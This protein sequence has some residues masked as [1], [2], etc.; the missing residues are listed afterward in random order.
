MFLILFFQYKYFNYTHYRIMYLLTCLLMLAAPATAQN[1]SNSRICQGFEQELRNINNT[2]N[3]STRQAL[4]YQQ[5]MQMQEQAQADAK[6]YSC[7]AGLFSGGS[8]SAEC[9]YIIM[10]Q[11]RL[12][13]AL[14]QISKQATSP[15]QRR[16][17]Q[18]IYRDMRDYNCRSPL[19]REEGV[20]RNR[21]DKRSATDNPMKQNNKNPKTEWLSPSLPPAT[22]ENEV[23]TEKPTAS[24]A[25]KNGYSK[26]KPGF[27][28]FTQPSMNN[29]K[30]AEPNPPPASN[31]TDYVPDPKIR[32]VGPEYAP[33]Q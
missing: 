23:R 21:N 22:P 24:D 4:R 5:L 30:A 15:Q 31:P 11:Q 18:D 14:N 6:R 3:L 2:S 8:N 13:T 10:S 1:N 27:S 12:E 32:R 9:R 29:T 28:I 25:K 17:R 33:D 7:N 16:M 20:R 19:G 26:V